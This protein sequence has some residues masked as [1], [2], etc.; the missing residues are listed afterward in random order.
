MEIKT[1]AIES[2][3]LAA[4]FMAA[5]AKLIEAGHFVQVYTSGN[6]I[7]MNTSASQFEVDVA[8]KAI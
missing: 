8:Y 1:T 2:R 7:V 3:N 5:A 4:K 6:D